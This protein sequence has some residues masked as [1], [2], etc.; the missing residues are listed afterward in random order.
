MNR[1]YEFGCQPY[2]SYSLA[3]FV[4]LPDAQGGKAVSFRTG[5]PLDI[6]TTKLSENPGSTIPV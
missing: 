3:G 4:F 5:D 1:E 6:K 2:Y